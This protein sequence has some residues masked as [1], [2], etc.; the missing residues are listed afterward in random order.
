MDFCKEILKHYKEFIKRFLR[1][2]HFLPGIRKKR[3][4]KRRRKK[5]LSSGSPSALATSPTLAYEVFTT[6]RLLRLSLKK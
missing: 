5:A 2:L 3:K 4:K 1:I 6:V